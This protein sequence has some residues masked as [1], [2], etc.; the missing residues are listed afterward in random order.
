[1][2]EIRDKSAMRSGEGWEVGG[3]KLT[4]SR[5]DKGF[6]VAGTSDL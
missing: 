3:R 4:G 6:C 2:G 5:A 1:V